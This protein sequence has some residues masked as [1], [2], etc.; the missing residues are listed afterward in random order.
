M[1]DM[2]QRIASLPPE[3]RALL[4]RALLEQRSPSVADLAIPR[5]D[6]D[7]PRRLSPAQERL[8]FLYQMYPDNAAYVLFRIWRL[9]GTLDIGAL[10][11]ALDTIVTRHT[12]LR[13]TYEMQGDMPVQVVGDTRSVEFTIS[14]I[15]DLPSAERERIVR[16][17]MIAETRRPFD[18]TR[19]LMMRCALLRL[20]ENEHLLAFI[21]HHIASDGWSLG[22]LNDELAT[23]YRS[24][25]EG[26]DS[27]PPPPPIQYSDYAQWQ[28]TYFK[29][30][31]LESQVSYWRRQLAGAPPAIELPTDYPRPATPA[32]RGRKHP[33][34]ITRRSH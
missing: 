5:R 9:R 28:R 6:V 17:R 2:G 8:W 19:D 11:K 13:T 15:P 23:L 3:K 29:A 10:R 12:V 16:E 24:F 4:E 34:S 31:A 20:S 14:D 21:M 18:L 26:S 22:V 25:V 27:V 7:A 30:D 33:L 32:F 1:T